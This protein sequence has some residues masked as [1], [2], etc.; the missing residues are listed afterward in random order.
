M[1]GVSVSHDKSEPNSVAIGLT[2]FVF[3]VILIGTF[4]SSI[5]MYNTFFTDI[6]SEKISQNVNGSIDDLRKSEM[7]ELST[8]SYID[9]SRGVVRLPIDI[10]MERVF[11]DYRRR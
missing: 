2:I 9:E 7:N 6:T 5:F 3:T 8:V 1:S 11:D 10:A 4:I